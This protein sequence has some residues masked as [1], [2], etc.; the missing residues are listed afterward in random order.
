MSIFATL[1]A[2]APVSPRDALALA[3]PVQA[4]PERPPF[5][6][7]VD[8]LEATATKPKKPNFLA[9][10][11]GF[12]P[13]ISLHLALDKTALDAARMQ[14]ADAVRAFLRGSRGELVVLYIDTPIVKRDPTGAWVKR[15]YEDL[16]GAEGFEVVDEVRIPREEP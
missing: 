2:T 10:D 1:H 4:I 8:G 6:I 5:K 12:D 13:A 16:V 9:D 15:G 11:F 7:A 14:L 3:F